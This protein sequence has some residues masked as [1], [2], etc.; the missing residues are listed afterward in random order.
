MVRSISI[1]IAI[2]VKIKIMISMVIM[3]VAMVLL[4]IVPANIQRMLIDRLAKPP[5]NILPML[6]IPI[7]IDNDHRQ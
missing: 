5:L 2:I 4:T 6:Y 3:V 7:T 1:T